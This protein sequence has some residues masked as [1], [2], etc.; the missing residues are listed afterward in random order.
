MHGYLTPKL[1]TDHL[2]DGETQPDSLGVELPRTL[3]SAEELEQ[4]HL[5]YDLDANSCVNDR[6]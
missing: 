1:F 6:K 4:L 3:D 5:I 2:G